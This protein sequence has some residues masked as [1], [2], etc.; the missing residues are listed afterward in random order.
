M[1]QFLQYAFWLI[2]LALQHLVLVAMLGGAY[3]QFPILFAYTLCLL[4]TTVAD[5]AI[6][7]TIGDTHPLYSEY[8]WSAELLRQSGLFSVVISLLLDVMP[9]GAQRKT[10][11]R[12]VL[13]GAVLFW[14]GSIVSHHDDRLNVWMTQVTR[15]LSFC[16]AIVNLTVWFALVSSQ[17]KDTRRLMIAGGL[18]LQMTGEAI[19]QSIRQLRISEPVFWAA[20]ILI[21][22]AHFVCLY[23]WWQAFSVKFSPDKAIREDHAAV[24]QR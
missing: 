9:A 7:F 6:F 17:V 13:S 21:V 24:H 18:G 12:L 2:G 3:R 15:N 8:Y 22:L 14:F 16:S 4:G 20:N 1:R 19:G 10:L 23:I 5:I 11:L